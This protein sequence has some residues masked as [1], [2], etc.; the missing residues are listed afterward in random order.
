VSRVLA[1][2][3]ALLTVCAVLLTAPAVHAA[4]S[5]E[6]PAARENSTRVALVGSG[7]M[8]FDLDIWG[9]G[10]LVTFGR[11]GDTAGGFG[12]LRYVEARTLGGLVVREGS[13]IGTAEWH[14]GGGWRAGLGGGY[15]Y[16]A[17]VR[18]TTG[19]ALHSFGPLLVGLVGYDFGLKPNFYIL[20]TLEGQLQGFGVFGASLDNGGGAFLW[21]PTLQAGVRF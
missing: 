17:I 19:E 13:L 2:C 4:D 16:F 5:D 21:G 1:S 15:T 7:Q 12:T 9:A 6:Q 11:E 8:M 3:V 18:A 20:G 14:W 10:A